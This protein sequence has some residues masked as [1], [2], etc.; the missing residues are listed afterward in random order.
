MKINGKIK[1]RI[2]FTNGVARYFD[3]GDLRTEATPKYWKTEDREISSI[4]IKKHF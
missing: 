3:T 4:Y 2:S 1:I